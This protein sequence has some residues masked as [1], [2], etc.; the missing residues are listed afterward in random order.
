MAQLLLCNSLFIKLYNMSPTLSVL[1]KYIIISFFFDSTYRMV[2]VFL[3]KVII[4]VL[5]ILPFQNIP[6]STKAVM[7]SEKI[8]RIK[9]YVCFY[10]NDIFIYFKYKVLRDNV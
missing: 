10:N 4:K 3:S 5:E 1:L 8:A 7:K 2:H 6:K 9:Q